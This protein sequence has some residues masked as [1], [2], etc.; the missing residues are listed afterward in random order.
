MLEQ[1]AE[2]PLY[3]IGYAV[4]FGKCFYW[5]TIRILIKAEAYMKPSILLAEKLQE[6]KMIFDR[7]PFAINPRVFGSVARGE[8]KEN[9]DLDILVD[10]KP[11]TSMFAIARLQNELEELFP[12]T[13]VDLIDSH[14]FNGKISEKI[15]KEAVLL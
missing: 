9:S 2:K 15:N 5:D 13:K 1:T 10:I 4:G 6:V 3:T 8:D 11:F 7:Y 14:S 12:Q